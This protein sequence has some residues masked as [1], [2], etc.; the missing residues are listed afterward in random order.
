[1]PRCGLSAGALWSN[2]VAAVE[3]ES[4]CQSGLERALRLCSRKLDQ[5]L[6]DFPFAVSTAAHTMLDR[7]AHRTGGAHTRLAARNLTSIVRHRTYST[8]RLGHDDLGTGPAW[9]LQER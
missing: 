2:A 9:P 6:E 8:K 3:T 5:S 7:R 1:P 4:R